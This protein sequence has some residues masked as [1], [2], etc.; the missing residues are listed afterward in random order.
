MLEF[1]KCLISWIFIL[2]SGYFV[3]KEPLMEEYSIA[4][5]VWKLSSCDMCELARYSVLMSGFPHEVIIVMTIILSIQTF[6]FRQKLFYNEI[7]LLPRVTTSKWLSARDYS[8]QT[9][10]KCLTLSLSNIYIIER[11]T[12][13]SF[14]EIMRIIWRPL[15]NIVLR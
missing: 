4:A 1:L 8:S 10:P 9:H 15:D 5:Q 3:V 12:T 6:N 2:K 14:W 11:T 7:K 13:M